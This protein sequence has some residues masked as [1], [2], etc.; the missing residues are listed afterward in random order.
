MY[1]ILFVLALLQPEAEDKARKITIPIVAYS[2][3]P[4]PPNPSPPPNVKPIA[5][6]DRARDV[7]PGYHVRYGVKFKEGILYK[8]KYHNH[9]SKFLWDYRYGTFLYFD[10]WVKSWYFWDETDFC[11]YPVS[12]APHGYVFPTSAI[13][14]K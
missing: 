11:Y 5:P 2:K 13:P 14:I 10:P 8:G 7:T 6:V 4:K 9:W 3:A 1:Q 12:Y